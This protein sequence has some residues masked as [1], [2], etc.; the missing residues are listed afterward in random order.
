MG[1]T[2]GG[3]EETVKDRSPAYE[4]LRGKVKKEDGRCKFLQ[5]PGYPKA[6]GESAQG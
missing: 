3:V 5:L 6:L 2:G 1:T 4:F